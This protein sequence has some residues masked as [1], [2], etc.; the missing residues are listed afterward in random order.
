[1]T[2]LT[3]LFLLDLTTGKKFQIMRCNWPLT[4]T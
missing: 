4:P 2:F 1:M 3:V